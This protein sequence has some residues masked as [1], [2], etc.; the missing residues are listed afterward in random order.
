M[1]VYRT[2]LKNDTFETIEKKSRF[3]C[4][5]GRAADENEAM[6]FI[7]FVSS[8]YKD[9]THNVY[10]Y[11]IKSNVEIERASDDGEPQGTAG[12]PVLEVLKR[13]RL[14]N[15][16]VVVTRYFGGILLGAGGLIRA[17]SNAVREGILN[18]GICTMAPYFKICVKI[19]YTYLGKIQNA[20]AAM[21]NTVIDS[22]YTEVVDLVIK[23]RADRLQKT[24]KSITEIIRHQP[25][26]QCIESFYDISEDDID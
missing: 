20:M 11:R 19:D 5:V 12:I 9:A 7:E 14:E 10:A 17:Y 13:E 25:D 15:I 2:V 4:S 1:E 22:N 3:I 8:M 6:K 23:V 16:C 21:G 26:M 24:E 18:A